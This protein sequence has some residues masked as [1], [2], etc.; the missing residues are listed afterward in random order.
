MKAVWVMATNPLVSLPDGQRARA[1]LER[2]EL[3]VVQDPHHPTETSSLAHAP[4]IS[5]R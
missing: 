1:A 2:A 3:V 4:G 5:R